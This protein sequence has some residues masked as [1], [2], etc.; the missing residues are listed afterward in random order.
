MCSHGSYHM[1]QAGLELVAVSCLSLLG[2]VLGVCTTIQGPVLVLKTVLCLGLFGNV[3][4]DNVEEL[5]SNRCFM[6][7]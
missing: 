2:A 6:D 4:E 7:E 3:H 1:A 5:E